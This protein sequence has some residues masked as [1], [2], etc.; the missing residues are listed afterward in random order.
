MLGVILIVLSA[1][2]VIFCIAMAV[3]GSN[4]RYEIEDAREFVIK[5]KI[6]HVGSGKNSISYTS[7]RGAFG[8]AAVG[9][10]VAGPIGGLIGAATAGSH[11]YTKAGDDVYHFM[12][13]Y[14]DGT[15]ELVSASE[16][17]PLFEVYMEKLDL[18][19]DEDYYVHVDKET[20]RELLED[21]EY[22]EYEY[23]DDEYEEELD[24]E[25][26]EDEIGELPEKLTIQ[27]PEP[28][29][30][31]TQEL[32]ILAELQR[33]YHL[34]IITREELIAKRKTILNK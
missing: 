16:E 26:E 31:D 19:D 20:R 24:E 27:L 1:F 23:E 32:D 18:G 8:R 21:Y 6:V 25:F 7:T 10:A 28:R 14:C 12:V 5:T 34:G 11:T 30:D 22:E 17:D 33:A 15:R 29:H 13:Y 3:K 9:W 2:I 4:D